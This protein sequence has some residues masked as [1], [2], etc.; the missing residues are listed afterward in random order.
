M[1]SFD[2]HEYIVCDFQMKVADLIRTNKY[3]DA[4]AAIE[5]REEKWLS[6]KQYEV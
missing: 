6:V 4:I 2:F 5:E 1:Q 3:A